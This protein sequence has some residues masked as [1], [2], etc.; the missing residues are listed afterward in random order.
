[1]KLTEIKEYIQK[2]RL[3]QTYNQSLNSHK[4]NS[5]NNMFSSSKMIDEFF[6][7][8]NFNMNNNIQ[9]EINEKVSYI[10]YYQFLNTKFSEFGHFSAFLKEKAEAWQLLDPKINVNDAVYYLLN[11]FVVSPVDGKIKEIKV[12][13]KVREIFHD[14]KIESPTPEED[15]EQCW[16]LRVSKNHISFYL[17]VKARNFFKGLS[18]RSKYSFLKIEKAAKKYELPI[19]FVKEDFGNIVINLEDEIHDNKS[20]FIPLTD[21]SVEGLT[22]DEIFELSMDIFNVMRVENNIKEVR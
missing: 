15:L 8:V 13:K 17:Q 1:M 12:E 5:V 11:V 10:K 2:N 20:E 21:F 18:H 7:S 6:R 16:D 3:E 19:F 9:K 22:Q 14:Y 4:I